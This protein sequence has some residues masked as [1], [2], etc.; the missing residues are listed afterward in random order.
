MSSI[1]MST[2]L[3]SSFYMGWMRPQFSIIC[4]GPSTKMIKSTVFNND[5]YFAIMQ[6]Y[7]SRSS[8][9]LR[10]LSCITPI[11]YTSFLYCRIS[12][13]LL[14]KVVIL[15]WDGYAPYHSS[16]NFGLCKLSLIYRFIDDHCD[17]Y[18]IIIG[19]IIKFLGQKETNHYRS[20]SQPLLMNQ[21]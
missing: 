13:F 9:N 6:F 14:I 11:S 1:L 5:W 20:S 15:T 10:Q 8:R 17:D 19:A 18:L 21:V 2:M 12:S 3:Y 16:T 4:L 7:F